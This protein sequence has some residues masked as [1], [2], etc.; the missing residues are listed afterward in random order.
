MFDDFGEGE[1]GTIVDVQAVVS[2][3]IKMRPCPAFGLRL[4]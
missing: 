3:E 1:D 4:R 2:H